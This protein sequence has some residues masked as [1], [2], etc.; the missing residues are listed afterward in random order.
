MDTN[1]INLKFISD[2]K[3]I[4]VG[5]DS[6]F[7][8]LLIEGLSEIQNEVSK[9]PNTLSDG[10]KVRNRRAG[11][12]PL[13][14]ECEY[15]G[16]DKEERRK[17]TASFFNVHNGGTLFI[18]YMGTKR[19][20]DYEIEGYLAPLPNLH[21]P[22][23]FLVHLNCPNPYLL[24]IDETVEEIV[25]WI[26]GMTF[27]WSLPNT[28]ATPGEKTLNVYN[29]GNVETPATYT[30]TGP[31]INPKI[32][33][34]DT[35]EYIQIDKELTADDTVVITT[36]YGNK[37]VELNG[38]NAF[39][40]LKLPGSSFMELNVGDNVLEFITDDVSSNASLKIAYRNRYIGV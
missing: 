38:E 32:I 18:D 26:G 34:R 25:T 37:R 27:P 24:D 14:I 15:T 12:R 6:P 28:F 33:N 30:I 5:K 7:R 21:M 10:S 16:K 8:L 17:Y 22:F 31:A 29:A 9:S 3:E 19:K 40:Y 4:E 39:N 36:G 1:Y 35:G 13:M 20:I 2:N 11:T 23:K